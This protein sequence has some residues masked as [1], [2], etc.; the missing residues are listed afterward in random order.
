MVVLVKMKCLI[1]NRVLGKAVV[2]NGLTVFKYFGM[3]FVA[4]GY[5]YV[6]GRKNHSLFICKYVEC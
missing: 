2:L 1:S 6:F 3:I 5:G 4:G